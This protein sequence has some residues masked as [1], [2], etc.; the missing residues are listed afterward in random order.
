M[1]DAVFN[2]RLQTIESAYRQL[3]EIRLRLEHSGVWKPGRQYDLASDFYQFFV[4][5]SCRLSQLYLD[6]EESHG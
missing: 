1:T 3:T 2:D 6:R 5:I 4:E